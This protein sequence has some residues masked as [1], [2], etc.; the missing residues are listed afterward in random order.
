[1]ARARTALERWSWLARS[2]LTRGRLVL[3][4]AGLSQVRASCSYAPPPVLMQGQGG[5]TLGPGRFNAGAEVGYG[6]NGSWWNT[7]NIGN[8]D[9]NGDG[10]GAVRVRAGISENW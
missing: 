4:A 7:Q 3:I 1:M 5:D 8:P 9:V 2:L 10:I 6:A